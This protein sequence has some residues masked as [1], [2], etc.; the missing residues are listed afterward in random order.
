M[1]NFVSN[2]ITTDINKNYEVKTATDE[3]PLQQ[4]QLQLQQV[5][6][7]ENVKKHKR[8]VTQPVY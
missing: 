1:S 5:I 6:R 2:T 8:N 3:Q 7:S 4:E